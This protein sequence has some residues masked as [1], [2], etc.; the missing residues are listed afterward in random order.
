[1]TRRVL[2]EEMTWTDYDARVRM[3]SPLV[4]LPVGSLEQHGPHSPLATDT[5]I[6]KA[7][8][9]AIA[10]RIGAIV[11]PAISYGYKSQVRTGG[12]NH[13]PGTTSLDGQTL[14]F[15]IRDLV[16]EF[17]RHGVRKLAVMDSHYENEMFLIEG[18]DLALRELRAGGIDDMKIVKARYFEFT[19]DQTLKT[20]FPDGFPGWPLEHAGVMTTSVLL[21]LR[22]D[23]VHMDRIPNHS[24]IVYPPYDVFPVDPEKASPTGVLASAKGA[25]AE[26]GA[27]L[28]NEYVKGIAAALANEFGLAG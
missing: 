26:K 13:F 27:L 10:E 22:P 12:G 20:V 19:S 17:A 14:T 4:I 15:I 24:P 5:I 8:S 23:L 21:Y 2:I 6:P 7:I 28:F 16:K 1:M 18:I 11:A 3:E 9:V 25:T